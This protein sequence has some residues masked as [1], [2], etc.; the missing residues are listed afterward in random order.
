VE[1]GFRGKQT[2]KGGNGGLGRG[3]G[4]GWWKGK[5][6]NGKSIVTPKKSKIYPLYIEK[7][8]KTEQPYNEDA[9]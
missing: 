2:D 8:K 3:G 4:G 5:K 1:W 9:A 7:V 6:I